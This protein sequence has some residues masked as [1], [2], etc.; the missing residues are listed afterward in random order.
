MTRNKYIY[1]SILCLIS[2]SLVI[3]II[4]CGRTPSR[5]LGKDH[6]Q[7]LEISNMERFIN[8]SFD[9]RGSSTVKD[10]TFEATDNYVYTKEFKD[11][12]PLEGIIRWVPYGEGEDI[13]QSRGLSRWTGDIVNLELPEDC[14]EVL[15]VDV[16]YTSSRDRTKNLVYQSVKGEIFAKEYREGLIDRKFEGWMEIVHKE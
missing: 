7:K 6:R 10:I 8:I 11:V 4:S 2:L 16:G 5:Y 14:K 1:Y 15:G 9:K 13:V 3:M 12:S